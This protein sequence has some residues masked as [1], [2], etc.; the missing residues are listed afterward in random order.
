MSYLASKK[1]SLKAGNVVDAPDGYGHGVITTFS[2]GCGGGEYARV[3]LDE[4]GHAYWF[5]VSRLTFV[6]EKA[7]KVVDKKAKSANLYV[8][9]AVWTPDGELGLITD[10]VKGECWDEYAKVI[11][12]NGKIKDYN[13]STGQVTLAVAAN[14]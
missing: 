10:F 2:A 5:S 3:R 11:F 9:D 1:T 6:A 12:P 8:R 14:R 13:V 4:N 7:T